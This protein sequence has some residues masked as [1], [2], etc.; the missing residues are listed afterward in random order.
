MDPF[1]HRV[2]NHDFHGIHFGGKKTLFLVQHP[3]RCFS[4]FQGGGVGQFSGSSG[5]F[6]G[7][8]GDGTPKKLS[9]TFRRFRS[10]SLKCFRSFFPKYVPKIS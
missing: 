6:L 10:L 1:V 9:I 3:Y 8:F 7:D 5:E 2:W 4:P